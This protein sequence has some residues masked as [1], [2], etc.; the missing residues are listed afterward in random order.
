MGHVATLN[1]SE[2]TESG[3]IRTVPGTIHPQ[4]LNLELYIQAFNYTS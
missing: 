3:H 2:N 4:S 1:L